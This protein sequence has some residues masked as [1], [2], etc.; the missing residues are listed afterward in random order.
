MPSES[1]WAHILGEYG[2]YGYES[3]QQFL[4]AFKAS[5][6]TIPTQPDIQLPKNMQG[7][8]KSQRRLSG[9]ASHYRS[10]AAAAYLMHDFPTFQHCDLAWAG[11]PCQFLTYSI[12]SRIILLTIN[13]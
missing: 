3:F 8:E 4:K 9:P 12:G 2:L 6:T 10:S 5:T 1:D 13:C 11:K 7:V